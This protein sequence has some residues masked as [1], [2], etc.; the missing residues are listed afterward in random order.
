MICINIQTAGPLDPS[1]TTFSEQ[2]TMFVVKKDEPMTMM[3]TPR[4]RF[5]N[6]IS[7]NNNKVSVDVERVRVTCLLHILAIGIMV[8]AD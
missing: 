1:K 7:S 2:N 4:D 3:M 6:V 8:L 5:E